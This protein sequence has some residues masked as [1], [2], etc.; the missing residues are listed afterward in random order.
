[1]GDQYV[2]LGPYVESKARAEIEEEDFPPH[3]PLGQAVERIRQK[4]YKIHCGRWLVDGNP[5]V[6]LKANS[7]LSCCVRNT[8][9]T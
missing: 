1:M 9:G 7:N 2:C 5:Q 3:H 4:G 6:N 8:I